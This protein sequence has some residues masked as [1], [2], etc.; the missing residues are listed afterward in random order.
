MNER[1]LRGCSW[2]RDAKPEPASTDLFAEA[3]RRITGGD[4]VR[5]RGTVPTRQEAGMRARDPYFP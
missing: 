5:A 3:S 2:R 4:V 1:D